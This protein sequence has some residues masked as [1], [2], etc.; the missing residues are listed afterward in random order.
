[1]KAASAAVTKAP[2]ATMNTAFLRL[3]IRPLACGVDMTRPPW[4]G[5]NR[6]RCPPSPKPRGGSEPLP[7]RQCRTASECREICT[8][9]ISR[10]ATRLGV[11]VDLHSRG[12]VVGVEEDLELARDTSRSPSPAVP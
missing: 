4:V 3:R 9:D 11:F 1:M 12:R 6:G 2:T 8:G 5:V 10:E 7:S